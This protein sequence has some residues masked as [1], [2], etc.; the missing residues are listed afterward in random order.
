MKNLIPIVIIIAIIIVLIVFLVMQGKDEEDFP[1]GGGRGGRPGGRRR[2]IGRRG[3]TWWRR[4]WNRFR[5]RP[6]YYGTYPYYYTPYTV[7]YSDVNYPIDYGTCKCEGGLLK[8]SNCKYGSP[9]CN[10]DYCI[11]GGINNKYGCGL[12]NNTW[13][14]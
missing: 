13:C 1:R 10:G 4:G 2:P 9:T 12:N 14:A 11:C 5:G 6:I 3:N 7:Y 8:E